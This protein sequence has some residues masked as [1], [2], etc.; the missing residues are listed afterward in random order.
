MLGVGALALGIGCGAPTTADEPIFLA[1]RAVTPVGDSLF[2]TASGQAAAVIRYDRRG[3]PRDTLGLGI[4]RIPGRVQIL[5]GATYVSDVDGGRPLIVV[6][7][8]AGALERTIPLEG[9]ASQAHQFAVLPDGGIVV[10][11][12]DARLLVVRRDS[13]S[14]FAPVE[15]GARP[16]LVLGAA[17][18]V[19]HAIPDK[20]ITLY[21]GFGHIR[22]RVDW[23]WQESAFVADVSQDSRGRIHFLVGD[24]GTSTFTAQTLAPATGEVVRWSAPSADGSFLI[25]R[26]GEIIP[27]GDRWGESA[28]R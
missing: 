17:G 26:L 18:G 4:L 27:A 13:T 22:W 14:T 5:D 7:G 1:G 24:P 11:S 28:A 16:S 15:V 10:E 23:P 9:T 6:F 3:R 8:L 2:A 12:Q 19:L 21:N 20:T 25:D